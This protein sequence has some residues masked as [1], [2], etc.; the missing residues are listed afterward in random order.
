MRITEKALIAGLL[1]VAAMAGVLV[2]TAYVALAHDPHEPPPMICGDVNGDAVVTAS[3]AQ[4]TLHR[5]VGLPVEMRCNNRRNYHD[6]VFCE[7]DE[8]CTVIVP[9]DLFPTE[10]AY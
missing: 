7:Q 9:P 8:A 1:F 5:A 6:N 10:D 3:D 4:R 2:C